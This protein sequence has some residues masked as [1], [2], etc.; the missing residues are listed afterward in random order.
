MAT[1]T[2]TSGHFVGYA[3]EMEIRAALEF[4][5]TNDPDMNIDVRA[6]LTLLSDDIEHSAWLVLA[7]DGPETYGHDSL[8]ASVSWHEPQ[9]VEDEI[10]LK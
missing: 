7:F 4:A 5:V 9:G 10:A 6:R 1:H 8:P 3:A 2:G